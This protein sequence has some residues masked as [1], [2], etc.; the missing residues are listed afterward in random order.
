MERIGL[1]PGKPVRG[2][3]TL[4][5]RDQNRLNEGGSSGD[6][7]RGLMCCISAYTVEASWCFIIVRIRKRKKSRPALGI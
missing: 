7:G 5:E 6:R 4:Q 1:L 2:Y 3:H